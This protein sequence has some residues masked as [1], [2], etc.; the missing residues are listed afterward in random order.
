MERTIAQA[1]VEELR[2]GHYNQGTREIRSLDNL[3]DAVGVLTELAVKAG[4]CEWIKVDF[5]EGPAWC[6]NGSGPERHLIPTLV[7]RWCG[8][9]MANPLLKLSS[10]EVVTLSLLNKLS[11]GDIANVL[12]YNYL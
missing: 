5:E 2:S 11:F 10:G 4:V 3:F 8:I 7:V 9:R 12:E 1:W 6:V